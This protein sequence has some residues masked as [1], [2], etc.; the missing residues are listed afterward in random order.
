MT[1]DTEIIQKSCHFLGLLLT[2]FVYIGSRRKQIIIEK[3]ED[4]S[5]QDA[6]I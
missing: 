3:P 5:L 2:I 4:E 6:K 1:T